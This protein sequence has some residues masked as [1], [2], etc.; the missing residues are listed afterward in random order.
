[1]LNYFFVNEMRID[2]LDFSAYFWTLTTNG[3]KQEKPEQK[4]GWVSLIILKNFVIE[5][6]CILN[7][8]T[9]P[10]KTLKM[11]EFQR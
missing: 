5:S 1:M 9:D 11:R 8:D 4:P 3:L 7:L 2:L 6:G 10:Q